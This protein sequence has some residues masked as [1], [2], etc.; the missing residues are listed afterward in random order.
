M[1]FGRSSP[2]NSPKIRANLPRS[3][4]L[5]SF[6]QSGRT[7]D[8]LRSLFND[9]S[10]MDKNNFMSSNRLLLQLWAKKFVTVSPPTPS[11]LLPPWILF[12]LEK[13]TR[14]NAF[15][16]EGKARNIPSCRNLCRFIK[17]WIYSD[18]KMR[19]K[20]CRRKVFKSFFL[21]KKHRIFGE[22]F[23][24]FFSECKTWNESETFQSEAV[25]NFK[26]DRK[27]LIH[28]CENRFIC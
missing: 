25:C 5:T 27:L 26:S 24:V 1:K 11:I 20:V 9:T 15:Q 21:A 2:R 8:T 3:Q 7:S 6:V 18:L 17:K 22:N 19:E 16:S 28:C 14:I 10:G 4:L 23:W 13:R 12:L